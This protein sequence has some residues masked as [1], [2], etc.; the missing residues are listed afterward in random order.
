M[1]GRLSSYSLLFILALCAAGLYLLKY[2]VQALRERNVAMQQELEA[3]RTALDLLRAEWVYLNRPQRLKRL[4][5][6][7]L[8][9]VEMAPHD[10]IGWDDVPARARHVAEAR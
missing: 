1:T 7:R 10:V 6:E 4:A 3:E 5:H 2:D 8:A 9:L